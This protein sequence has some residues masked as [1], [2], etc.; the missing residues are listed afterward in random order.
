M[1]DYILNS[2][3]VGAYIIVFVLLLA[4]AF[5]LPMPEDIALIGAG[6]LV[7]FQRADA[8]VM[9][10]VCYVGIV[11]GDVVI[12]RIGYI[13]GPT[14]FRKRWFRKYVT[15][16]RLEWIRS[17]LERRTFVTIFVARHL[18]YLRTA[19]FLVCGAVRIQ[20]PRFLVSDLVA[21]L[22]TTPLMLFIGYLFAEHSDQ[23]WV[24]VKQVKTF[25]LLFGLLLLAAVGYRFRW[26]KESDE[27][28][29]DE[30]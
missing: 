28:D 25:L 15:S 4:G 24:W 3:G 6:F 10:L 23:L 13:A 14:L 9:A 8:L 12:Y 17:N 22:I 20:F 11:L 21:A 27:Q 30:S 19:T 29:V 7:H 18:F 5:G 2:Q 1:L 16:T 26:R